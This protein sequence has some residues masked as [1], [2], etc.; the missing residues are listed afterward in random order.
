MW[1][2]MS[3]GVEKQ[4]GGSGCGMWK[5]G[6]SGCWR[7]LR[8]VNVWFIDCERWWFWCEGQ[9][10]GR[11]MKGLMDRMTGR[12][13]KGLINRLGEKGWSDL[14]LR[15]II[16]PTSKTWF[17]IFVVSCFVSMGNKTRFCSGCSVVTGT[18]RTSDK[19][20]LLKCEKFGKS[21]FCSDLE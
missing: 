15:F 17:H 3:Q 9:L 21:L 14:G 1:S 12:K 2:Q 13:M 16:T 11:K 5:W 4:W 8:W 10:I 6:E 19:R 20:D 7:R 18:G